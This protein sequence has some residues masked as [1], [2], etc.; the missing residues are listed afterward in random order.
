MV[1]VYSIVWKLIIYLS[2]CL[3]WTFRFL[4]FFCC[5]SGII[6]I[7]PHSFLCTLLISSFVYFLVVFF[8][9]NIILKMKDFGRVKPKHPPERLKFKFIPPWS[10]LSVLIFPYLFMPENLIIF[11]VRREYT[12]DPWTSWGL[13]ALTL[14]V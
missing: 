14:H 6:N 4:I 9:I 3:W 2:I 13:G 10:F 5:V 11:N 7:F 8:W 12:V 1:S